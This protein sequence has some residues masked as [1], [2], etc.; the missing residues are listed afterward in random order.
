VVWEVELPNTRI[1]SG[2][3][4]RHRSSGRLCRVGELR[5]DP[6]RLVVYRY[7]AGAGRT[8]SA[9]LRPDRFIALFEFA[10][11]EQY[12]CR[13]CFGDSGEYAAPG[14]LECVPCRW[15]MDDEMD[16]SGSGSASADHK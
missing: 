8:R 3:V 9:A 4:W 14:Q 7:L 1:Q 13:V 6:A 15:S 5:P 2:A 11:D 16:A 10:P 12:A